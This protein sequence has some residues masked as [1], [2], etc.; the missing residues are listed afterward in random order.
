VRLVIVI[1]PVFVTTSRYVT[2]APV[3]G[4]A[5]VCVFTIVRLVTAG[6]ITDPTTFVASPTVPHTPVPVTYAVFDTAVGAHTT[7]TNPVTVNV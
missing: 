4:D 6:W 5:G 2:G 7:P 3:P 1:I